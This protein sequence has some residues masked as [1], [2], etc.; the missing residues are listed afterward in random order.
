MIKRKLIKR[1]S[2]QMFSLDALIASMILIGIIVSTAAMWA[3]ISDKAVLISRANDIDYVSQNA[4]KVLIE[5][6]GDPHNWSDISSSNFNTSNV[7]SLGLTKS[8]KSELDVNKIRKL[9]S[10]NSTDYG[11]YQILLGLQGYDF[12]VLI[13]TWNNTNFVNQYL[14]GNSPPV[15]VERQVSLNRY[16]VLNNTRSRIDMNIWQ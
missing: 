8:S 15:N 5:S 3:N 6:E 9:V 7:R 12:E 4:F 1:K 14:I 11:D 10:L 2:A 16:S 13:K